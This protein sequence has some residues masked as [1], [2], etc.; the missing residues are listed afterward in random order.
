MC[1]WLVFF[2]FAIQLCQC[3]FVVR[4]LYATFY[5]FYF[6][7]ICSVLFSETALQ[8]SAN[9]VS[10]M[11]LFIMGSIAVGAVM[12]CTMLICLSISFIHIFNSRVGCL[13]MFRFLHFIL[14]LHLH[15]LILNTGLQVQ[16]N[17]KFGESWKWHCKARVYFGPEECFWW[18]LLC[19]FIY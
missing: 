16:V 4:F 13:R 10:I 2:L 5:I 17:P 12:H 1:L 6:T 11:I 14:Y 3:A 18:Q 9:T 15:Y 7:C 19:I 8:I